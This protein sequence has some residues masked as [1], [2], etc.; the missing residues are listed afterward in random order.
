MLVLKAEAI[1]GFGVLRF[2]RKLSG[3]GIDDLQGLV[4]GLGLIRTRFRV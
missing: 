4:T 3:F 1:D 2:T